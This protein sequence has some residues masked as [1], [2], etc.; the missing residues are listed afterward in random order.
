MTTTTHDPAVL[1]AIRLLQNSDRIVTFL[2]ACSVGADVPPDMA[3]EA[4]E[5]LDAVAP[6]DD[7]EAA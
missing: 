4:R 1:L 7:P 2:A 5:L 3:E 6:K